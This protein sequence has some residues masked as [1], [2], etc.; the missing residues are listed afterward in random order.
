MPMA[1]MAATDAP[2]QPEPGKLTIVDVRARPA[3]L[4]GGTG[5][6]YFTVLNGLDQAVQLVS[7]SSPAAEVVETHET[8]NENGVMKMSPLPDGYPIAA[9][10]ALLLQPGGKHIMLIGLVEP[11]EPGDEVELTVN[12]DNGESMALTVP[13]LDMQMSGMNMG[14]MEMGGEA[15]AGEGMDAGAM[16]GPRPRRND[17]CRPHGH[18]G[19]AEGRCARGQGGDHGAAAR[20]HPEGKR[21]AHGGARLTR[22]LPPRS[23]AS[24]SRSAP[25]RGPKAFRRTSTKCKPRQLICWPHS[26]PATPRRPARWRPTCTTCSTR[27]QW[28]SWSRATAG[29][30]MTAQIGKLIIHLSDPLFRQAAY[31]QC[32]LCVIRDGYAD[33]ASQ[34]L[35]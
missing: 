22:P 25:Q 5:A 19:N 9:G 14:D 26:K 3:P 24:S 12:F 18:D 16:E 34:H 10:E 13:V 29:A 32:R 28:A 7:A 20:G 15:M 4:A 8:T 6:V 31:T 21:L 17:R 33:G 30:G 1:E 2:P 11:L 35:T 27:S 23:P